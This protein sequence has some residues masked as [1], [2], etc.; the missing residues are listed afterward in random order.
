MANVME[1]YLT[2]AGMTVLNKVL[3][4]CVVM[5]WNYFTKRYILTRKR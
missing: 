5:V 4:T 2:N 3:A 1:A